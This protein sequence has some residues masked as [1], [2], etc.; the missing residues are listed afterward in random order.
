MFGWVRRTFGRT[1]SKTA[2]KEVTQEVGQKAGKGVAQQ[3]SAE[4]GESSTLRKIAPLAAV[5]GVIVWGDDVAEGIGKGI[6][7]G[8]AGVGSVVGSVFDSPVML[9]VGLLMV[10]GIFYVVFK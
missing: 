5:G 7:S 8:I 9:G 4:V 10:G 3:T 1:A 6:G 2:G